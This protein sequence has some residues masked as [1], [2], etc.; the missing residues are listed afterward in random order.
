VEKYAERYRV[1]R[2]NPE[3]VAIRIEVERFVF[4]S[5]LGPAG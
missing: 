5:G 1:P 2:V 4:S 3:R